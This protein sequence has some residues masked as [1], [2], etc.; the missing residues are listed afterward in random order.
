MS[1]VAAGFSLREYLQES[2][3]NN[4]NRA[5]TQN[6]RKCYNKPKIKVL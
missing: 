3:I 5:L 1:L 4:E 6:Y 2:L